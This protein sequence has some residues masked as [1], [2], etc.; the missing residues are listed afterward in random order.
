MDVFNQNFP[1]KAR[2][3]FGID[4][5]SGDILA[6]IDLVVSSSSPLQFEQSGSKILD[7]S[8]SALVGVSQSV[9]IPLPGSNINPI[10]SLTPDLPIDSAIKVVQLVNH[11]TVVAGESA[12]VVVNGTSFTGKILP[13]LPGS[14]TL[15]DTF[16]FPLS[17]SF[18]IKAYRIKFNVS[19]GEDMIGSPVSI[20]NGNTLGML[21][22]SGKT[23]L[24]I[25][26]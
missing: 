2:S 11:T 7:L 20:M 22:S 1:I 24:V 15:I 21:L 26:S 12:V 13:P 17:I 4:S 23:V 14:S 8:T 16:P 10:I 18:T 9:T 19:L 5:I 6:P 3:I 25:P